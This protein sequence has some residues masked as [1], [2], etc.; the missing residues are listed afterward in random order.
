MM[1]GLVLPSSATAQN[2]LD[3]AYISFGINR[4]FVNYDM[5]GNNSFGPHSNEDEENGVAGISGTVALGKANLIQFGNGSIRAEIEYSNLEAQEISTA[6]FPGLPDPEF[7]YETEIDRTQALTL[8]TWYDFAL[9]SNE[10][11]VLS[12]GAGLGAAKLSASTDDTVVAGSAEDTGF[13]YMIGAEANYL[14][15]P[16]IAL[17]LGVR[18]SNYGSLDIPLEDGDAGS[19]TI[20]QDAYQIRAGVRFTFG[21]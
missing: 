8:N 13:A 12:L 4:D 6:S 20:D 1:A 9:P 17:G 15:T 2:V 14:V 18:Y 7:F 10:K 5:G 19:L 3:G 16:Q 21:G 11:V